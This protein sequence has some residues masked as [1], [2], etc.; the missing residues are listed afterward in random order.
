MRRGRRPP[1]P[2]RRAELPAPPAC[3]PPASTSTWSART[4]SSCAAASPTPTRR[5]PRYPPLPV[6]RCAGYEREA[7]DT[8]RAPRPTMPRRDDHPLDPHPRLRPDRH[9][10][11]LRVRLLGHPG[12]P[13]AAPRGL[14]GG[15]GQLEPG[16]HHDRPGAGRRHLRRAADRRRWSERIIARERPDALLPTVGGQTGINLTLALE[17]SG[18]LERF[19]VEVLGADPAAL[20]LGED[21]QLFK[22][23]MEEIGLQV[24]A[25]RL[26]RQPRRGAGDRRRGRLPGD[27]APQLHPRRRGRRRGLQPRRARGRGRARA[28]RLAGPPRADRAA[29]CSAGRSSS[30][31]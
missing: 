7:E 1:R 11:G 22:Q 15:A 18:A 6:R 4:A 8:A 26:R 12:L 13:R 9:R 14:P 10:P 3:A 29:R 17:E 27:R 30:S 16:D 2:R 31:R 25:E 23:A 5:F 20:R 21:R 28:R 19:G 24:P